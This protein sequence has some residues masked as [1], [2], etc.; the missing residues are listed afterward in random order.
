MGREITVN[1]MAI[2]TMN[3]ANLTKEL[4]FLAIISKYDI[5]VSLLTG[6][7]DTYNESRSVKIDIT[8]ALFQLTIQYS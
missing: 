4:C 3:F 6:I 2:I 5:Y 1:V 8:G 7:L